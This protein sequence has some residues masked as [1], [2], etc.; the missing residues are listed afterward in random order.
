MKL[1]D[2]P[3]RRHRLYY[4]ILKYAVIALAVAVTFYTIYKLHSG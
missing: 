4:L 2:V 3:F 1:N